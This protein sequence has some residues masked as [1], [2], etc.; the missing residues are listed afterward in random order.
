MKK[1]LQ[2]FALAM[3]LAA[4][5]VTNAQNS[6][7]TICNGTANNEYVPFYGYYADDDQHNQLIYP[8]DSLTAMIGQAITQMVFYID[9]S[10]GNGSNTSADRL[11]IWTVSLGITSATTLNGL[12][13]TT[14][15]EEVYEGY[16]DCST[17]TL[18]L[19]F[20][21]AFL[22]NGG[23]LLVDLQHYEASYNHWFFL[24]VAA[25]GASYCYDSQWNFLP[26]VQFT[27]G[28][29]P[30]CFRVQS[31]SASD[32]LSD[33]MT[34][35]WVDPINSNTTYTLSYWPY[36]AGANDTVVV[37]SISDTSYTVTGLN[38]STLYYFSVVPDCSDG[39]V[40]PRT[41]SFMTDCENGSCNMIVNCSDSYG[42][43][44]NGNSID[45]YQNGTLMGSATIASGNANTVQIQV[46]K[47]S[48]VQIK[49]TQ[50]Q[51]PVE[52]GGTVI[53]GA[54]GLVFTIENMSNYSTGA[55]LANV[56]NA[57]P[58]CIAPR[59]L[60]DSIDN[61]GNVVLTW[62]SSSTSFMVYAGDELVSDEVTDTFYTFTG[63]NAG[64]I[65]Q[66]G[67]AAICDGDD[68]SSISR[69]SIVTPCG[70]ITVPYVADF[71]NY[72]QST[73]MIWCWNRLESNISSYGTIYPYSTNSYGAYIYFDVADD[74][75]N[76]VVLP[77]V[78]NA[79]A[80]GINIEYSG[81]V[82]NSSTTKI[83][84][85]YVTNPDS[86]STFVGIDTVMAT[87]TVNR[88][89]NTQMVPD[90][91]D[92][93]WIAFRCVTS[94]S[95]GYAYLYSCV[96][97][98]YSDCTR[99]EYLLASNVTHN[100]VD[101]TWND[102]EAGIYQ[103]AVTTGTN[104]DAVDESDLVDASDTT[105]TVTGL[106]PSTAYNTWVRSVCSDDVSAWRQGPSIFTLCGE[107]SCPMT[108]DMVD[109][110]GDGWN[111]NAINISVNGQPYATTTISSGSS[112]SYSM[113]VC[114]GDTIVL[115][116][117]LGSFPDEASFTVNLA[118]NN[119]AS[120]NG[121]N[122][123][124]GQVIATITGCPTCTSVSNLT[125][126]SATANTVTVHWTRGD[127]S[128][129]TWAV[130][131][132]GT[133]VAS[134]VT[135]TFYTFTGL[136]ANTLYNFGVATVCG[137]DNMSD[138]VSVQAA[139]ACAGLACD[140]YITLDGEYNSYGSSYNAWYY[141]NLSISVYQ[142]GILKGTTSTSYEDPVPAEY[143]FSVCAGDSVQFVSN[144]GDYAS[145]YPEVVDIASYTILNGTGDV[146]ASDTTMTGVN[147]GA[148]MATAMTSCPSCITP[149]DVNLVSATTNSLTIGCTNV[150]PATQWSVRISDGTS[151]VSTTTVTTNPCTISGLQPGTYY[152]VSVAAICS[153]GDTSNYSVPVRVSTECSEI[154]LPWDYNFN[155]DVVG[156]NNEMPL[157]WYAP[158]SITGYNGSTT[159]PYVYLTTSGDSYLNLYVTSSYGNAVMAAT[160]RIPAAGNNL[161]VSFHAE[162]DNETIRQAGVMT[163]VNDPTTFIPLITVP[164]GEGDY[165]FFTTGV[166]GLNATDTVHIAFRNSITSTS[167]TY[168]YFDLYS[169]H[170]QVAPSCVRP[171]SVWVTNATT[172][173]VT[174]NWTNT[175]ATRYEVTV[176]GTV[177]SSTTN[178]VAITGLQPGTNYTY[179]LVGICSDTSIAKLGGF[180]TECPAATSIPFSE[181]FEGYPA[182]TLPNCWTALNPSPDYYGV[183]TP[184]IY[185]P[186]YVS[187][188]VHSGE[189]SLY[190]Y[191]N[192]S[193]HP[194][195]VTP[196]LT[197]EDIDKLFVSFWVY[198]SSYV[199]FDAGFMTDP[200]ND[201]TFVP[202]YSVPATSYNMVQYSFTTDSIADN[203]PTTYHFAI[204]F[205]NSDSYS[206]SMY[207]DDIT[208]VSSR[209]PLYD[210]DGPASAFVGEATS[211]SALRISGETSPAPAYSWTSTMAAAGQAV[212]LNGTT[213]SM[214]LN[215]SAEGV[216]TITLIVT[217]AYGADT[218]MAIVHVF[219]CGMVS[220]FPYTEPFEAD[221]PCWL[222]VY[223]D[224]DPNTNTM[225][226]T[227]DM[228]YN[229]SGPHGGNSAFRF[230]SY[231]SSSDYNQYLISPEL[232]GA[233]MVLSFWGANYGSSDHLW[234]GFSSTTRDLAAFVWD[235]AEVALQ[236][237]SWTEFTYNLPAG[238]KYVAFH[239]FG[240]FAYYV[241]LDDLTINGS[242][243]CAMPVITGIDRGETSLTV[244]YTSDA[245]SVEVIVASGIFDP[246]AAGVIATGG[247]YTATGLTH[248]TLYTIAVRA[249]C[250]DEDV[251]EWAV[252][253]DSTLVVNCG[254]PT[255]LAVEN[256]GYTSVTL[257][258]TAAGEEH[259]WEV[260][261]F[262]TLDT[263]YATSNTTSVTVDG[264]TAYTTYNAS[265]RA[266]CGQNADIEGEWS[267]PIQV[268]TNACSPVT[269]VVVTNVTGNTANVSWTAPEGATA[270]RVIYGTHDF[271]QGG[272]IATFTTQEAEYHITGL[273]HNT[274]YTVRVANLCTE[275]LLSQ[276]ASADF[277]TG[278]EGIAT[279]DAEGNLSIYPNP[280]SAMVTIS[281]S[282]HLAGATATIVDLNGRTVATFDLT[283]N[284][285][286]FDVSTL[287]K[288]AYF[289]R[290]T[291]EQATT[292]R[293]LIVK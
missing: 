164:M 47:G 174:L 190:F 99:P 159:Y 85:G 31:I 87:S 265:V 281:V 238:T 25:T 82:D 3:L 158:E 198:G 199:G 211:F 126:D 30:S 111:G 233:N 11:G 29:P 9:Q 52:M 222:P 61:E 2:L 38:A 215:Y 262:N 271:D 76:C 288:G 77:H 250:S 24:G 177:F 203:T 219:N 73:S 129:D 213:D 259:G 72:D 140:V 234:V 207:L 275:T 249:L 67:V 142:N 98:Q 277:T 46:C 218:N 204:R 70:D 179:S 170:V 93:I 274:D 88:E 74:A 100:S 280:A 124:N 269:D 192:G 185:H 44:W 235:S 12:D 42:D 22:Y 163:N 115:T 75:P 189:N 200:A 182:Q 65:Y 206:N 66:L 266:L 84:L 256:T 145:Y 229:L 97:T 10:A 121:D 191:G 153:A 172:T 264:L 144:V 113:G 181:G 289:V 162:G 120:G 253:T 208:I 62:S 35:N 279:V 240:D 147:N 214:Q 243:A 50:G 132:N 205:K 258:W 282:E 108:I 123:S 105:V 40:L 41:G 102:T 16:F 20:V 248:S 183:Q 63:L 141:T 251:S 212:M 21:S 95:E 176:D 32:I 107:N 178:S 228:G 236:S 33:G 290:I 134:N 48:P 90:G 91:V 104:P 94:G 43:G 180:A 106:N 101:L 57:C 252:V 169:V 155:T 114:D 151:I 83:I 55:V 27:Y 278:T 136:T 283:D 96:L 58:D 196:A 171:D 194:M 193:K 1:F 217:N 237:S 118:G 293:K 223:G 150:T 17:G 23:N 71:E 4:P 152:Y 255:G 268:T 45:I 89:V 231:S 26:K 239:Y 270:F 19:P 127:A 13:N 6:T 167:S 117:T 69:L 130:K 36:N 138:Y 143:T 263:V 244:N 202:V 257:G 79:A 86:I 128:D 284:T 148:V 184:Y 220:T 230:S 188:S 119:I 287:A 224:G 267:E 54:G 285:A 15:L 133:V 254:V 81:Y 247:S 154:V 241:Y 175:G 232:N 7:L 173:G 156:F 37:S 221:N 226:V 103:V 286:T 276:Y 28:N 197:G 225:L 260:V 56:A 161:Y 273:E 51:Y 125:V 187:T 68:T 146:I 116:W 195:I 186:G 291:G 201:S 245:D 109:G 78:S 5:W 135:D 137:A 242:G 18:T 59:N 34:V 160:S 210:I 92:S 227:D 8:A 49:Y 292:V 39:S 60:T 209:M 110:Y 272:E 216:D 261:V 122:Y 80:N 139:T 166:T 149:V 157:C 112:N 53:D 64:T 246:D 14:P 165:D 168:G 131:V